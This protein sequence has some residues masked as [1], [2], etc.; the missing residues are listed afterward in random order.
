MGTLLIVALAAL[1]IFLLTYIID[2][3][4]QSAGNEEKKKS[5]KRKN[6]KRRSLKVAFF[7]NIACT[8]RIGTS[9]FG[10]VECAK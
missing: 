4:E 7:F 2:C 10:R 5:V 6:I 1:G 8:C 3:L 9:L